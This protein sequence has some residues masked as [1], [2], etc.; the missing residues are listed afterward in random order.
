MKPRWLLWALAS[1]IV[2]PGFRTELCDDPPTIKHATFRA[3]T[4]KNGTM[5]NCE[6][7]KGFRRIKYGSSY[8]LCTGN[9]SHSFWDNKCECVNSSVKNSER[10]M[11]TQPEEKTKRKTT[12]MQSPMQPVDQEHPLGDCREPPPWKHEATKRIYHFIVG[13]VVHYQCLQ[14][15]RPIQRVPATSVC[16]M[17][18]G[19]T[20][21]TQPQLTCT[22]KSKHHQFPDK[23]EPQASMDD[24]LESET[25]CPITTTDFQKHTEATTTMETFL[26]TMEYQ[27][28]VAGC[29]F[30]LISVLLLI[31]LSWQRRWKK[32]RRTI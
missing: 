18:C 21:W 15:Y 2:V 9:S 30:L 3:I 14:G 32:S 1:F 26:F 28:A 11:T 13:Q 7:E 23:E 4:Y 6:C 22:N 20:Q 25:S 19:K 8:M 16:K 31:A 24:P 12:E 5:L 27:V 10:Q 29:V 17:V